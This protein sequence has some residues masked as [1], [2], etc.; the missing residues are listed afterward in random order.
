MTTTEQNRA[1]FAAKADAAGV[2]KLAFGYR[3]VKLMRWDDKG[4]KF[5]KGDAFY[6]N[7]K[8]MSYA[9]Q[10][11]DTGYKYSADSGRTWESHPENAIL[12]AKR[13]PIKMV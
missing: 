12:R 2:A 13:T 8:V 6:F 7:V 1:N 10:P 9:N 3:A 11:G 4:G 5:A